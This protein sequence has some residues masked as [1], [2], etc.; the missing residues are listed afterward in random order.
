MKSVRCDSNRRV[1]ATLAA[2]GLCL[3]VVSTTPAAAPAAPVAGAC[4]TTGTKAKVST[5]QQTTNSMDHVN[6]TETAI[7]FTQGRTSCV[8]VSFSS[9][10]SA[11]ANTTM[12][13]SAIID[14]N[15]CQPDE[16]TFV[17]SGASPSGTGGHAMNFLCLN[18]APGT[19]TVKMQ[20]R[21]VNGGDVTLDYRTMIVHYAR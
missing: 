17:Q 13:V 19:H 20:F 21:S 3:A 9:E 6:V 10:A 1:R 12:R 8:I 5:T 7:A 15:V 16:S 11:A 4:E 2:I 14:S 18:V